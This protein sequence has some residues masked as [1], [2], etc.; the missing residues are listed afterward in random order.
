MKKLTVLIGAMLLVLSIGQII[1]AKVDATV[2]ISLGYDAL[3]FGR[4]LAC[5]E[6]FILALHTYMTTKGSSVFSQHT[7]NTNNLSAT[8]N[9]YWFKFNYN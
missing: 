1:S 6:I 8:K 7:H 5:V 3:S 9:V 4:S 2:G